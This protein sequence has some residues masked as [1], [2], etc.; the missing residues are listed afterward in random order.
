MLIQEETT[1]QITF[2][3]SWIFQS[4]TQARS[5]IVAIA[6]TSQR[7][8][9]LSLRSNRSKHIL[10]IDQAQLLTYLLLSGKKVGLLINFKVPVLKNGIE[11][12][13]L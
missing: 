2:T 6:W 7:R 4:P 13:V 12:E 5:L 8:R 10:P 3:G 9:R 11:K 1:E